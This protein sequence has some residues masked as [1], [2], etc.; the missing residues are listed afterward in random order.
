[1]TSYEHFKSPSRRANASRGFTLVE[2]LVVIGIIALLI[3]ILLPAL[4]K[5]REQSNRTKCLANLRTLGQSMFMYANANRDHLPNMNGPAS[6][7]YNLGGRA[8]LDMANL[9]ATA[10]VFHCPSD[11]DEVPNEITT[12]EYFVPDS[13]H[14]SYEFFSIWWAGRDGPMLTRLL[15]RAPLAWDID[16]G[17]P[18]SPLQNHGKL[19]GNIMFADG[20]AEWRPRAEWKGGNWPA[21]AAEFYAKP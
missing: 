2:L 12:A 4:N 5:A 13:A 8:L 21:P 11:T 15:G 1:M 6:Y 17:E 10:G 7:D 20:H 9:Y 19:G 14:Q 18:K 16:G 3:S